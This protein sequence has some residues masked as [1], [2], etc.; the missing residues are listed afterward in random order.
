MF[1]CVS[2]VTG[3]QLPLFPIFPITD[4]PTTLNSLPPKAGQALV[5]PLVFW[6][7][8]GGGDCL[9]SGDPTTRLPYYKYVTLSLWSNSRKCDYWARG[10]GFDFRVRQNITGSIRNLELYQV[11]GNLP[12]LHVSEQRATKL[13]GVGR[14][15]KHWVMREGVSDS[16][17]LKTT[18]FLKN[19]SPG[20]LL[21]VRSSDQE[22]TFE[23]QS[24]YNNI[25]NVCLSVSPLVKLF[26]R[27][28][29][30]H[31]HVKLYVCKRT[32]HTGDNP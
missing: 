24:K 9:P 21:R 10:F 15:H 25:N 12:L 26:A 28:K 5:T 20:N 1:R 3:T 32:H 8:T 22:G 16:N 14:A 6:V 27:S 17:R 30:C 19:R 13:R 18:P 31:V 7:Y 11:Y 23:R 29:V 4:T 2:E